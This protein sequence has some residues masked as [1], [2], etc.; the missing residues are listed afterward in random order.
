[1]TASMSRKGNCYD[2][3]QIE[4]FWGTLK[5]EPVYHR[6]YLT[7]QEAIKDITEYIEIF[8]NRQRRQKRLA[9]C[10]Q[11]LTRKNIT[12]KCLQRESFGLHYCR[13]TPVRTINEHIRNIFEEGELTPESVVWKYSVFVLS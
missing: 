5:N 13:L 11:Q 8:Y 9:I 12:K 7:R 2:N 6:D 3:A 1:M 4:S 10:L